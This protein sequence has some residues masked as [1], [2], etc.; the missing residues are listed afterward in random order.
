VDAAALFRDAG[1]DPALLNVAGARVPATAARQLWERAESATANPCLGLEAA[2]YAQGA[3]SHALGYAWLA[4]ATLGEAIGRA[5]RFARLLGDGGA[6]RLDDEPGGTRCTLLF[7]D[8]T[9]RPPFAHQDALLG[10]LVR[11]C[12]LTYGESFAPLEVT[13]ARSRPQCARR[14]EQWF[15]APIRWEAAC[16]SV[17]LRREDL[18]APLPTWNP[19]IAAANE[20]LIIEYLARIDR[21]D[22][23]MRVKRLLIDRL[24]ARPP[25]QDRIAGELALSPRT[26]QRRLAQAGTSFA[27]L[28]EETRR[29]LALAHLRGGEHSVAR[30]AHLLG[31]TEVSSFN[32]AFRRWT[33]L[34]PSGFRRASGSPR[35]P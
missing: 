26:L 27:Q 15:R 23:V 16:A 8:T 33:G 9:R 29:E 5:V 7:P 19:E 11:M 12:R 20:R 31:F 3:A 22:V 2:Q 28:L 30:I 21:A 10:S 14:F 25:A 1:C 32:R 13:V 24:A 6:A 35:R 18:A 34:T 4:S 17:L